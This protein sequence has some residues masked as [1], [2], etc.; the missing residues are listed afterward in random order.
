VEA[1]NSAVVRRLRREAAANP[2]KAGALA[3]CVIIAIWFWMPLVIR[4]C[5]PSGDSTETAAAATA[6]STTTSTAEHSTASATT[7][8]APASESVSNLQAKSSADNTHAAPPADW[9]DIMQ[10]IHDDPRMQS[11]MPTAGR[12]DP[13]GP[14]T[15]ELAAAAAEKATQAAQQAL[16][17]A[18]ARELLPSEAGLVL[19]STLIGSG[20]PM[21]LIGGEPYFEGDTVPATGESFVLAQI[22]R[23]Q[24]V[25]ERNGKQFDLEIKISRRDS[26]SDAPASTASSVTANPRRSH[27]SSAPVAA[28]STTSGARHQS[29]SVTKSNS[30]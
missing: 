13:F 11:S 15:S 29:S 9:Q 16:H 24:V 2:V 22:L 23:R 3:I 14:S 19:N 4:W 18:P 17:R 25:L 5:S 6:D 30:Q 20:R 7:A 10:A 1:V 8:S 12:R 21:A 28:T 26:S 27:G